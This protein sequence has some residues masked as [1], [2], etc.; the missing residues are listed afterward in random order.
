[1]VE[2]RAASWFRLHDK[3]IETEASRLST[4]QQSS[5]S[6]PF[7]PFYSHLDENEF[8]P[9]SRSARRGIRARGSALFR[10]ATSGENSCPQ[11]R[12]RRHDNDN[13]CTIDHVVD[14]LVHGRKDGGA[15]G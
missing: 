12:V 11:R 13:C 1:M 7:V 9:P 10:G 5:F 3:L 6:S 2:T 14:A 4:E 8:L 15:R